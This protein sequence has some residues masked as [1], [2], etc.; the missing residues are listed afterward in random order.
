MAAIHRVIPIASSKNILRNPRTLQLSLY[1][2]ILFQ[3]DRDFP[4]P[5]AGLIRHRFSHCV[6]GRRR[7]PSKVSAGWFSGFSVKKESLP[8]IVKAGDPVLHEPAADVPLEE[9][10]SEKIQKIID[11]MIEVMRKA[12]GVGLAAPQIGIPL[13]VL[14]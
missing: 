6:A 13:R 3:R 2:S 1:A 5:S 14:F 10:G 8:E 12:P 11:D 7:V 9:I 4:A